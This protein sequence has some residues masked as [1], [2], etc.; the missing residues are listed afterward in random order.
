LENKILIVDDDVELCEL[1]AEYL[2]AEKFEIESVH[3]GV[4]GAQ[5]ALSEDF[6]IIILDIMLPGING[7]EALKQIRSSKDT[8]VI[9]LTAKGEDIDRI[10]GLE[11]GADD[12]LP[13]PYNPRELLARIKAILR[14]SGSET[15]A[16]KDEITNGDLT[17]DR[18]KL[19]AFYKDEDKG[20]TGAEFN[21]LEILTKNA[22]NVVKREEIAKEVLGRSLSP[23]DR[24]IDVHIS[25][26]RKKI[27]KNE[28][29]KN[30]RG[31]GYYS[32]VMGDK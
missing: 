7:L 10:I 30:V 18:G 12:Y 14:R 5:R 22:G 31:V 1:L 32:P 8:P 21:V 20:L 26:I 9:M 3:N 24:S 17:L 25:N 27:G 6:S 16:T 28:I 23:F 15:K 13:K 29:I 4:E 11:I 19:V 2:G